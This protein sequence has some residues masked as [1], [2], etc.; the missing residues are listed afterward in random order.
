ML[1]AQI[2]SVLIAKN[3]LGREADPNAGDAQAATPLM[4]AAKFNQL[5]VAKL[6]VDNGANIHASNQAGQTAKDIALQEDHT[7]FVNWITSLH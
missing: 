1:A 6:L 7:D 4:W 3:L 2:G 5:S